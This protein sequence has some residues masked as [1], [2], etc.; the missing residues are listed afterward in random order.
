MACPTVPASRPANWPLLYLA[1]ALTTLATLLLELSLTRFFRWFSTTILRF[2]RSRSR[3]SGWA[4][5][6]CCPMWSRGWPGS[7]YR[8]LGMVSLI[9]AGLVLGAVL[10]VLTRGAEIGTF[11][12]GLIYFTIGA[13]VSGVGDHRFAG[14]CGDDRA[15]RQR[16]FLRSAGRGG[17]MSG[18][19]AAA[20]TF[21]GPNTVIAVSVLFAAAAAIW[22]SL[23]GMRLGRIASVFAGPAVHH[24]GDRQYE[25]SLRRSALRQGRE[26]ARGAVH[27]MEQHFAHRHGAGQ[28]W[29]AR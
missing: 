3:C 29:R 5:A 23:A 14:D 4:W 10:F 15:R 13:A 19:G 9:N 18:A 27:Q 21:G 7:L 8:K 11:D 16:L 28:G 17:R 22:F 6:A 2:W 12:L 20:E 24:A 25:I 1:V 26:A